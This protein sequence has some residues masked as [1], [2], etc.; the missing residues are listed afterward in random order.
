[1]KSIKEVIAHVWA[2][3]AKVWDSEEL[4]SMAAK[5]IS[6]I[7]GKSYLPPLRP[8]RDT[9][10]H[11]DQEPIHF[12]SEDSI[13]HTS[14]SGI[15]S[16]SALL[17]IVS[18]Q[19]VQEAIGLDRQG[20]LRRFSY[21]WTPETALK[22]SVERPSNFEGFRGNGSSPLL[23]IAPSLMQGENV[24][25]QSLARSTRGV[26]VTDLRE[27]LEGRGSLSN[28]ALAKPASIST[29]EHVSSL[30]GAELKVKR[31]RSRKRPITSENGE[32]R[33]VLNKLG[34]ERQNGSSLLRASFP[35]LQ[36][37]TN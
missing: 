22:D 24:S 4:A 28:P 8:L 7:P 16:E 18:S 23:K 37:P 36:K 9:I 14:W 35:A 2:V 11:I 13:P 3:I 5:A 21:K 27:A 26:G 10:S 34:I 30:S 15:D 20:L 1:V 6:S 17:A 25:L 32:V 12:P 31:P 33:D 29:L 19:K